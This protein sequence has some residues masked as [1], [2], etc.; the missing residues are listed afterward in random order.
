MRLTRGM[1]RSILSVNAL[2]VL[3][4][5]SSLWA[6]QLPPEVVSWPELILHNGQI[7]T[8]DSD[9]PE[10]FTVAEALAIRGGSVLEVGKNPEVLSLAGPR[11]RR[12]DLKGKTVIPGII[13]T[14]SHLFEYALEH[15]RDELYKT[16]PIMA[17]FRPVDIRA[18]SVTEALN[19]IRE[20]VQ[21]SKPGRW[22]QVN[23]RSEKVAQEMWTKLSVKDID[24]ISPDNPLVVRTVRTSR[25][26]NSKVG[27]AILK[28]FGA[29]EP[30]FLDDKGNYHGRGG[31]GPIRSIQADILVQQPLK[32]LAEVYRKELEEWAS[33]G[34]TTWSSSLSPLV[35]LRVYS[36]LDRQGRMPIRFA[37]T[38]AMAFTASEHAAEFVD[39]L[40]DIVGHGTHYLWNIGISTSAIDGS[41]PRHCTSLPTNPPALKKSE[42]CRAAPG[43][44]Q[45]KGLVAAVRSGLRLAGIHVG[46]DRAADHFFQAIEEGSRLGGLS[47]EEIR[48]KRHAMD[49]CA[50]YPRPDQIE[51]GKRFGILWG[52]GPEYIEE[53]GPLAK[54]FGERYAHEWVAPIKRILNAGGKVVGEFD[55]HLR[56][57]S[58]F[59]HIQVLVTRKDPDGK[60]WGK[61]QA[62]DRKT[63]LLMFTRWAAEYVL[64]EKVFGSLEAGKWA[65]LIILD[66]DYLKVPDEEFSKIKVLMTLVGGKI[67]YTEPGFASSEGLEHAG[68][69]GK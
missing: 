27:E 58:P 55:R 9:N 39:R 10:A 32:S 2:I 46:G 33:Y 6:Q 14:H 69:R 47:E 64:R 7:L 42:Q 23:V 28:R 8:A 15:W 45:Y 13:D 66:R 19:K 43:S 61:D 12:I 22:I 26:Y 41:Y 20:L 18:E 53:A 35:S 63:A 4:A 29:M 48:S 36:H 62:I 52:C 44:V 1:V 57:D 5:S 24:Q 17:E 16:E 34:I 37:Y 54:A 49:H 68:Y 56:G 31:A 59:R 65:D 50:F 40:G 67:V 38:H 25:F 21:G 60:I 11:T 3:A 51:K 30:D